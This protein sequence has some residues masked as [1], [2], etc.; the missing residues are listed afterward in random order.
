MD[1]VPT[2]QV[3]TGMVDDYDRL[4]SVFDEAERFHRQAVPHIFRELEGTFPSR[5]LYRELIETPGSSVLVAEERDELIG[6]VTMR[7]SLA[8]PDFPALISRRVAMV[9]MLAVRTDRQRGGVGRALMEAT[10]AWALT[11][12]LRTVQLDVWEFNQRAITFYEALG[13]H[14][15]MRLME[16]TEL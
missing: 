13:Y 7:E 9:D 12:G 4:Q 6:F 3:R 15:L 8:A 14:S 10:H 5:A 16:R 11:Q 1:T 2:Y